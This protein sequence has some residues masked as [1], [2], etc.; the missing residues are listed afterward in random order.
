MEC[1]APRESHIP[2]LA[3]VLAAIALVASAVASPALATSPSQDQYGPAIP[4][5]GG[6]G[7]NRNPSG[8]SAGTGS[9]TTIPVAGETSSS[10][11]GTGSSADSSGND[12]TS[13][14]R[15]A[16]GSSSLAN[17]ASGSP[18]GNADQPES[19]TPASNS[20]PQIT[21]DSAGDSWVPFFIA[22]LVAL[23]AA[24]AFLVYRNRRRAA[25]P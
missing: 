1:P 12:S 20:V 5:V 10:G 22:G 23:G 16:N 24:G 17:Q 9:E 6:G 11:Q 4:G 13:S 14:H 21:V 25:Q 2:R 15:G 8:P 7:D 3:A 19:G 18:A